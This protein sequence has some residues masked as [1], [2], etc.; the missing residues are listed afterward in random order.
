MDGQQCI[1]CCKFQ[2]SFA[3]YD[4]NL[5]LLLLLKKQEFKNLLT[6]NILLGNYT[7][8]SASASALLQVA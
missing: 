8:Y 3:I 2:E 4:H 6:Q 5:L 7:M 1:L